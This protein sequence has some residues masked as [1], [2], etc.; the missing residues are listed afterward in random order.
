MKKNIW[1]KTDDTQWIKYMDISDNEE[2]WFK[3]VD[4]MVIS[5]EDKPYCIFRVMSVLIE[6]SNLNN[7]YYDRYIEAFYDSIEDIS[8][9][10]EVDLQLLA[11][12]IAETDMFSGTADNCN[13]I[14]TFN[15]NSESND[16]TKEV[17]SH[18]DKVE[19]YIKKYL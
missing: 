9:S 12:I 6:S 8:N 15:L 10:G 4:C 1:I 5:D 13:D 19:E 7:G 17:L 18:C 16:L 2:N 11:E 14:F 3:V